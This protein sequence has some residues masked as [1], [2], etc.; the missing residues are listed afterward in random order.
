MFH[1]SS[2]C[3]GKLLAV[4]TQVDVM[5]QGGDP[6]AASPQGPFVKFG[7]WVIKAFTGQPIKKMLAQRVASDLEE[8]NFAGKLLYSK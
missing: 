3:H 1:A 5:A 6:H 4:I 7:V 2:V 8:L